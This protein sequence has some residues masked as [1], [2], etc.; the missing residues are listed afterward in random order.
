MRKSYALGRL[1]R[2]TANVVATTVVSAATSVLEVPRDFVRGIKDGDGPT[3]TT[4]IARKR[5]TVR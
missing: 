3:P 5:R 1:V 2:R 4:T